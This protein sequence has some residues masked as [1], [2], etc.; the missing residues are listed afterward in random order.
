M[1]RVLIALLCI[2]LFSV[3]MGESR[4]IEGQNNAKSDDEIFSALAEELKAAAETMT[5]S[6]VYMKR[7][8]EMEDVT[9]EEIA[10]DTLI[11]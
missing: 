4:A 1:N 2:V 5:G 3:S 6:S 10:S 8:D 9:D 7:I 11:Y